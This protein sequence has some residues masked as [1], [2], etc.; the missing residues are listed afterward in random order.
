MIILSF[1]STIPGE[2]RRNS[3]CWAYNSLLRI[4]ASKLQSNLLKCSLSKRILSINDQ[5]NLLSNSGCTLM[6]MFVEQATSISERFALLPPTCA[7][8]V[9]NVSP[10]NRSALNFQCSLLEEATGG[11]ERTE[12]SSRRA[13][14]FWFVN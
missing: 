5:G 11:L 6:G 14:A 9:L 10:R 4:C 8:G 13:S 12:H 7:H 2:D 3:L 1:V